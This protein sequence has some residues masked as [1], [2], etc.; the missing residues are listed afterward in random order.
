MSIQVRPISTATMNA[1]IDE[2]G[3]GSFLQ[4]PGWSNAKPGWSSET[5]GFYDGDQLT[6]VALLLMRK[7]PY[8]KRYFVYAPK[9][10]VL[11][12][13]RSDVPNHLAALADYA[14]RK[15]AFA[16]RI[17]PAIDH[18]EWV[19]ATVKK[20]VA[21]DDTT[22]L[23]ELEPEF[24]STAADRLKQTLEAQAWKY[25]ESAAGEDFPR[26]QAQFNYILPLRH[27]DGT[28]KTE[29]EVLKG[30]N[31][32]WRRNI[33]KADKAGVTVREGTHDDLKLFHDM[34]LETT[35]RD[36]F[37][38]RAYEY[39]DRIWEGLNG[40]KHGRMRVYVAEHEGTPVAAALYLIVGDYASYAWGA[41]TTA[42]REVRGSN[43]MQWHMIQTALNEGAARYDLGG[44]AQGVRSDHPAIG[45]IHFKAGTGGHAI[46]NL[47]E[48]DKVFNKPLYRLFN[49]YLNRG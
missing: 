26:G 40:D 3:A 21:D 29:D 32:Q 37:T 46:A 10:P 43:G 27:R 31:Q 30:M 49:A 17:G 20:A 22:L 13:S 5:V 44:I 9:G 28:P 16:L 42:K 14:K 38:A 39:F 35:E 12:W 11:D 19:S 34:Y 36:G 4:T 7:V 45:L 18:R 15:G 1:Y 8:L 24:T 33:R 23:T 6:G 48:W 2:H 47:G 25:D 41:S